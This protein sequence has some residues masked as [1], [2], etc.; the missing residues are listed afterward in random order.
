MRFFLP[1]PLPSGVDESDADS[2][3]RLAVT[4]VGVASLLT[5]SAEA[6]AAAAEAAAAAATDAVAALVD[7]GPLLLVRFFLST[8]EEVSVKIY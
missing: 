6:A 5:S 7:A 3:L 2:L 4:L 8:Y 1:R